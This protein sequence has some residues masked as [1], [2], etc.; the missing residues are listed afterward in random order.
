MHQLGW[1]QIQ[2]KLA[3][4]SAVAVECTLWDNVIGTSAIARFVFL[5][6]FLNCEHVGLKVQT[7][8]CTYMQSQPLEWISVLYDIMVLDIMRVTYK[9]TKYK[10]LFTCSAA[11]SPPQR[12]SSKSSNLSEIPPELSLNT[13]R[14]FPAWS[15]AIAKSWSWTASRETK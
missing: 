14:S 11:M 5:N 4:I 2:W 13:E 8:I 3:C 15:S 12:A 6:I 9:H 1:Y 10:C 7:D